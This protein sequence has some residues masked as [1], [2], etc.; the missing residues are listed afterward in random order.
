MYGGLNSCFVLS[1][2]RFSRF[3]SVAQ[4]ASV[5]PEAPTSD[6][7][8]ENSK[9]VWLA[10]SLVLVTLFQLTR[11]PSMIVVPLKRLEKETEVSQAG[12]KKKIANS[13]SNPIFNVRS[14]CLLNL[15]AETN[16]ALKQLKRY[17]F[18]GGAIS[19][20]TGAAMHHKTCNW[21]ISERVYIGVSAQRFI[22]I[23]C[24]FAVSLLRLNHICPV[25]AG[26]DLGARR[27]G[28]QQLAQLRKLGLDETHL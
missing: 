9:G 13:P 16:I 2:D 15:L 27:G 23:R 19:F 17:L 5:T 7:V 6:G 12:I 10:G 21:R 24:G 3:A 11:Y 26:G 14:K 22:K 1:T 25:W 4:F 20:S 8:N 28:R 18:G